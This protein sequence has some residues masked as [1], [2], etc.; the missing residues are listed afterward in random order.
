MKGDC[1]QMSCTISVDVGGP[2]A[3]FTL[4]GRLDTVSAPQL[5]EEL[6]KL[7]GKSITSV[8]FQMGDLDYI[9]SAGLRVIVFAKQK[10][11]VDTKVSV[12]GAKPEVVE[13][14]KMT[15]FDSF[16]TLRDAAA[17]AS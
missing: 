2:E 4:A 17:G 5:S 7:V 16:L 15:G 11:G 12:V 8:V 10:L 9:S 3:R 6:K 13:V 1:F 14:I